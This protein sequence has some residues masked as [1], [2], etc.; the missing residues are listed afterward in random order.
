VLAGIAVG[1]SAAVVDSL[2]AGL[3]KWRALDWVL[4]AGCV[5][6]GVG[7]LAGRVQSRA[8]A[9]SLMG[10]ASLLATVVSY[11]VV[12]AL[13]FGTS[14]GLAFSSSRSVEWLGLAVVGGPV[15]GFVGFCAR[16]GDLLGLAARLAVPVAVLVEEL[17]IHPLDT[18]ATGAFA[19]DP[20]LNWTHAGMAAVAVAWMLVSMARWRVSSRT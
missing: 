11:Y 16:R 3:D 12:G 10:A 1:S 14:V 20:W 8:V 2:S 7:V 15:L 19:V 18:R 5:W 6:A 17:A 4:N 13:R 9:A